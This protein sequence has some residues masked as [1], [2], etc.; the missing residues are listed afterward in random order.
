MLLRCNKN[1]PRYDTIPDGKLP[2]GAPGHMGIDQLLREACAEQADVELVRRYVTR[3]RL[4]VLRIDLLRRTMIIGGPLAAM[5]IAF[6]KR[7][8]KG[9]T[10]VPAELN[11][12][13][14]GVF[15]LDNRAIV[16][17]PGRKKFP[18]EESLVP[19]PV[20]T[21]TRRPK[22]FRDL[23]HFPKG[24]TGKGQ[25]I[26]VLEFG[27]G[28]SRAKLGKYLR[29]LGVR[30]PRIVVRQI[31]GAKN[32]PVNGSGVLSP[33]AEVY[34]DLE[35]LASVAPDATLVVYFA[36]NTSRGWIEALNA[37][38]FDR[39]NKPSVLSISW[40]Q[41]EEFWDPATVTAVEEAF[42]MAARL[43][44]TVCCSSG[45]RGVFE[46][47][48]R[49]YTVPYPASSPHVLA[50]GGTK[51]QVISKRQQRESVWNESRTA[52]VASGGGISKFFDLPAFQRSRRAP[53]AG[54]GIPDV[55]ANAASSTGYLIWADGISMSLGG[56]S[57]VAPLWA[58]LVACLNQALGRR[59]GYLTSLL[60]QH[61]DTLRSVTRG[62]N[63]L[64]GREGY[65]ARKGWDP[66]TGLGSPDGIKL[67]KRLRS[68]L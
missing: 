17:R 67:L 58:G 64:A 28:F 14:L 63:R 37:A 30:P 46:A 20:T 41:A 44:M 7:R 49:A 60:Y 55:A 31:G 59:I 52:G 9:G 68:Q 18:P 34:M 57:A 26:A 51:L 3:H 16:K 53:G 50:C 56:T 2:T 65:D 27:G 23:Y 4:K 33:D 25:S 35:I 1:A 61:R 40:G 39:K 47:G 11:G 5:T 48:R 66:C 42:Q 29:K 15:G 43:R 10:K 38:I 36:E 6:P 45:D 32:R 13:V 8:I 24:A 22:E 12:S 62:N 54:R 21:N 19:P